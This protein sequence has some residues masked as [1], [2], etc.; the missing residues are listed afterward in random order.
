MGLHTGEAE[1]RGGD[2]FGTAVNR[3]SRLMGA[4]HG[5]QILVS[6]ATA[7]LVGDPLPDGARLVSLGECVT[8]AEG[9]VM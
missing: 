3:A 7:S 4:A 6:G 2:Y 8:N 9:G 1:L 5:G